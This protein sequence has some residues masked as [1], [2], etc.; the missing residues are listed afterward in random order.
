MLK[1]Y[2]LLLTAVL[3]SATAVAQETIEV[4]NK[5]T[6]DVNE[7]FQ[8]RADDHAIKRG[9]YQAFY[10]KKT[11]VATGIYESNRRVGIWKFYNQFG[12]SMQ[13]YDFNKKQLLGEAAEDTTSSLHYYVDKE[14]DSTT[15]A[16]KPVKIGGRYYGYLP[17]LNLF[18]L[19]K[20]LREF[21]NNIFEGV[22]ELLISPLGRL[23]EYK[24]H[25]TARNFERVIKMNVHLPDPDDTVFIPATL[26]GEPIASR[27][28]IRC[29]VTPAGHLDFN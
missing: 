15:R 3:L 19:P 18:T 22:V 25:L 10:K 24:V 27:V 20:D 9:L 4:K 29:Y 8:V 16:T 28:V 12:Q 13:V 5:L 6:N 14:L 26:N 1:Y 2:Y 11:I 7:V 17:Y 21:D 23:A